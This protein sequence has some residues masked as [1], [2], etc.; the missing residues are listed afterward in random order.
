MQARPAAE[1]C[2]RCRIGDGGAVVGEVNPAEF[3]VL[4]LDRH[5]HP[6]LV[7]EAAQTVLVEGTLGRASDPRVRAVPQ[8]PF[9][10][11][12]FLDG[13]VA[14]SSSCCAR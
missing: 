11:Q 9:N 8:G 1:H 4:P 7:P 3:D 6:R 5:Q 14:G 2:E 10:Q 12:E 13:E